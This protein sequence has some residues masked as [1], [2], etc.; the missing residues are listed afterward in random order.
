MRGV[1][2][3]NGGYCSKS[4]QLREQYNEVVK[5]LFYKSLEGIYVC[6]VLKF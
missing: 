3:Q 2:L 1:M 6:N 4:E 5:L